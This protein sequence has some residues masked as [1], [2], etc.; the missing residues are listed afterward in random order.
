MKAVAIF[1]AEYTVWV[2]FHIIMISA[3]T[4]G[5]VMAY[6]AEDLGPLAPLM[7]S[8]GI[9]VMLFAF[10]AEA[11]F[12]IRCVAAALARHY[13]KNLTEIAQ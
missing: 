2:K 1:F 5:L 13:L 9:S 4:T 3:F 12:L 7:I 11:L 6:S 10:V 8:C